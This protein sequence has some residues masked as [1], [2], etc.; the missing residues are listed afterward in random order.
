MEKKL[1]PAVQA[2]HPQCSGGPPHPPLEK[3]GEEMHAKAVLKL[4]TCI[5]ISIANA[6]IKEESKRVGSFL[7]DRLT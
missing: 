3:I 2:L 7:C 6:S 5:V 1:Q 4:G